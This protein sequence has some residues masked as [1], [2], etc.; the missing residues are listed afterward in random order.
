MRLRFLVLK[1][2][3]TTEIFLCGFLLFCLFSTNPILAKLK[4]VQQI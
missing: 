4:L 3:D 1:I 2:K